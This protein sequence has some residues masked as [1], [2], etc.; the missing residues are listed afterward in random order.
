MSG[1][2]FFSFLIK[3]M[4]TVIVNDHALGVIALDDK[5]CKP[6]VASNGLIIRESNNYCMHIDD[7]FNYIEEFSQQMY[8]KR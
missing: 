7:Y 8:L 2:K 1:P 4:E 5:V 3:Y 6:N